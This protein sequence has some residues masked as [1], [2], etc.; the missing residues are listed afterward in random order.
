MKNI[1]GSYDE[2]WLEDSRAK[3]LK[4]DDDEKRAIW[5]MSRMEKKTKEQF[6]MTYTSF[7]KFWRNEFY[8]NVSAN[9]RVQDKNL[10]QLK[11]KVNDFFKNH[12]KLISNFE[13]VLNG[14]VKNKE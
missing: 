13:A 7:Y 12:G 3:L 11:I 14:D 8:N 1:L 5:I 4:Q 2:R 9:D 10:D 6:W